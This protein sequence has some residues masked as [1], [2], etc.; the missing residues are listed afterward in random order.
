M[1][2]FGRWEVEHVTDYDALTPDCGGLSA[3]RDQW[4]RYK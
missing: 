4:P 2:G 1:T 3:R